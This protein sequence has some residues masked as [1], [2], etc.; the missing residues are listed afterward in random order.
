MALIAKNS[1]IESLAFEESHLNYSGLKALSMAMRVNKTIT[2]LR[3]WENNKRYVPKSVQL[4]VS[5][6]A[7]NNRLQ[8]LYIDVVDHG[9]DLVV[10]MLQA[11]PASLKNVGFAAQ[12]VTTTNAHKIY[13][14][15]VRH[16]HL[17]GFGMRL[18]IGTLRS[19]VAI[20]IFSDSFP[21]LARHCLRERP[22]YVWLRCGARTCARVAFTRGPN[23]LVPE[24]PSIVEIIERNR[25]LTSLTVTNVGGS[26]NIPSK[27]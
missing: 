19:R 1:T 22:S 25:L 7:T 11:S 8:R 5:W 9:V 18:L 3:V 21:P 20:E 17:V 27:N 6:V 12:T 2:E 13:A 16:P 15:V 26:L 24:L 23:S 4:D 14:S 10:A